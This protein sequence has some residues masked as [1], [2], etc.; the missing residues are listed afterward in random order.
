MSAA[1]S[2][3]AEELDGRPVHAADLHLTLCFIGEVPEAAI[4]HLSAAVAELRTSTLRLQLPQL[5]CWLPSHVLCLLPQSGP[6]VNV[7]ADLSARL[8]SVSRTAGLPVDPKPFRAH[9]TVA[10]KLAPRQAVARTWPQ[11]LPAPLPFTA[12]EFVLMQGTGATNGPRY[13]VVRGWPADSGQF[14]LR[15]E[16]ELPP[17]S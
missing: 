7:V 9:V 11:A 3:L 6:D 5:D 13:A 10:R 12:N 14:G 2:A 4:D 15:K 17:R 8:A 16:P 1:A